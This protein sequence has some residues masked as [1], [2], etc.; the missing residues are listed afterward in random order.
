MKRMIYALIAVIG[1]FVGAQAQDKRPD[2]VAIYGGFTNITVPGDNIGGVNGQIQ[3][4][5]VRLGVFKIE[6]IGDY[7]GYFYEVGDNI[8]TFHGGPGLSLDLA[9]R[10]VTLFGHYLFGVITTFNNDA[11]YAYM[12]GGGVRFNVSRRVFLQG[13]YDR[14]F[15]RDAGDSFNRL[16]AGVGIKLY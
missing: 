16:T 14:Q 1:L 13:G 9:D 15:V 7:A 2:A 6:A 5:L 4:K 11:T 8:H 12:P 3:I 10:K